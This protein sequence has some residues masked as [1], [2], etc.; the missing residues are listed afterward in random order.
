MHFRYYYSLLCA[1][2]LFPYSWRKEEAVSFR[3]SAFSYNIKVFLLTP[4]GHTLGS[5]QLSAFSY[6]IGMFRLRAKS[7]GV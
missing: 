3:P 1:G 2:D 4:E 7:E 6:S 5:R